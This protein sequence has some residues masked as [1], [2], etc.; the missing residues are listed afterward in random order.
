M[1]KVLKGLYFVEGLGFANCPPTSQVIRAVFGLDL[2]GYFRQA[3]V[4]ITGCK[5]FIIYSNC[6]FLIMTPGMYLIFQLF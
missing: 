6:S 1:Q 3:G 5:T 4:E 2:V